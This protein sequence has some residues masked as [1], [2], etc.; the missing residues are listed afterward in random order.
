MALIGDLKQALQIRL[1]V[2]PARSLIVELGQRPRGLYSIRPFFSN[3]HAGHRFAAILLVM[4][5]AVLSSVGVK[6]HDASGLRRVLN[7]FNGNSSSAFVMLA[8]LGV[9]TMPYE[10]VAQDIAEGRLRVVSPE[11]IIEVQII[12][13]WRRDSMGE[14]KAWFLREIPRIFNAN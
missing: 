2:H 13:A 12:M 5:V 8:G 14:A 9:A 1:H 11:N 4:Q 6:F 7:L 10:R 3:A